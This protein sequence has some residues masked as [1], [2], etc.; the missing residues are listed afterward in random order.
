MSL[1]VVDSIVVMY[2]LILSSKS[3]EIGIAAIFCQ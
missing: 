2:L 3:I 1:L